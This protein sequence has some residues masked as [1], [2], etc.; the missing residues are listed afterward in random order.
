METISGILKGAIQKV[1]ESFGSIPEKLSHTLGYPKDSSIPISAASTIS[2][3]FQSSKKTPR[4]LD[5]VHLNGKF[6]RRR[7]K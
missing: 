5:A 2:K 7:I 1:F 4:G 6:G 3:D